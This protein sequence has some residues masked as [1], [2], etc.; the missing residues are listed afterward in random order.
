MQTRN[1]GPK[2]PNYFLGLPPYAERMAAYLSGDRAV[3]VSAAFAEAVSVAGKKA[4]DISVLTRDEQVVLRS[5]DFRWESGPDGVLLWTHSAA[6]KI[7][8]QST[9]DFAW[10]LDQS[11]KVW[12]EQTGTS[13]SED[14]NSTEPP[15]WLLEWASQWKNWCHRFAS[16]HY[17]RALRQ[18]QS[19]G[20]RRPVAAGV[21]ATALLVRCLKVLLLEYLP[22][23]KITQRQATPKN[24][25]TKHLSSPEKWPTPTDLLDVRNHG[26]NAREYRDEF[27][28]RCCKPSE[29]QH[30]SRGREPVVINDT[31]TTLSRLVQDFLDFVATK[32]NASLGGSDGLRFQNPF[33]PRSRSGRLLVPANDNQTQGFTP[34][35][36]GFWRETKYVAPPAR[37]ADKSCSWISRDYPH[38]AAWEP[39]AREFIGRSKRS[40][41]TK[42]AA[43]SVFVDRY[44]NTAGERG[45]PGE[46]LGIGVASR[47]VAD[48]FSADALLVRYNRDKVPNT[49]D[50]LSENPDK[51]YLR[52]I[53]DEFIEDILSFHC[54]VQ[55]ENGVVRLAEYGNPFLGSDLTDFRGSTPISTVRAAMPYR[56]IRRMR[57]ILVPGAHFCDWAWAQQAQQSV[58]GN[59]AD[60][61]E[62]DETIIDREDPDC[63]WRQRTTGK[64]KDNSERTFYEMWSPV[65]WVVLLTKLNTALRTLQVRV[66][67][68]GESD[69]WRFDLG[70]W[71]RLTYPEMGSAGS[72]APSSSEIPIGPWVRNEL[73]QRNPELHSAVVP[74]DALRKRG[75]RRDPQDWSNGALRRVFTNTDEGPGHFDTVLYVNTNKSADTNK[76]G[77]AKGFEIPLPLLACPLPPGREYWIRQGEHGQAASLAFTSRLHKEAWLD[78]LGENT[79]WWLAKLRNWQERYNPVKRRMGWDQLSG[80]G[81]MPEKSDE[82][83]QMY[84]PACFLFREPAARKGGKH[85]GPEYPIADSVVGSAWWSLNKELQDQLNSARK[86]G[87]AEIK[88]VLNSDGVANRTCV[89][90]LHSIRV[91]LITALIVDGKVPVEIVQKMVGH[92]RLVMTIYYTVVSPRRMQQEI[93]AGF[94]RAKEEEIESE[95]LFL[96]NASMEELRS[97]AA[98]NDEAS[99]FAALGISKKPALRSVV[100]WARVLGGICPVGAATHDTEGGLAA[101]CFNGGPMISGAHGAKYEP[102]EGGPGTCVN[103]RFLT[104]LPA[105]LGELQAVY[106][107]AGYRKHEI[108]QR[109]LAQEQK[110]R[111][112]KDAWD[113]GEAQGLSKLELIALERAVDAA[114]D[115]RESILADF[116]VEIVTAANAERLISRLLVIMNGRAPDESTE[117]LV[118]NGGVVEAKLIMSQTNSE[119]LHAARISLHS[120]LHPELNPSGAILRASQIMARKLYTEGADPFVLLALPEQER[121]RAMNAA[122]RDLANRFGADNF[123]AGL[124]M[125]VRL[126]ES[127]DSI[128][129]ALGIE[130][131]SLN[132][133]ILGF[134]STGRNRATIPTDGVLSFP[135]LEGNIGEDR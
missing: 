131:K 21:G 134:S 99:A 130:R 96:Q 89:F 88:L 33:L 62:V 31:G 109:A 82:Q 27:W 126:I 77:A 87:E 110:V 51:T 16:I 97:K 125:A 45:A 111:D 119:M 84:R 64:A 42:I 83:Y 120:E 44:L 50:R 24:D 133:W 73:A 122:I 23:S 72:A 95:R 103:C 85:L 124:G 81:L 91:S 61:F 5:L 1:A 6:T 15:P 86:D 70:A 63:V 28:L 117:A 93:S 54:S 108:H 80:T 74:Q 43:L 128:A 36:R 41:S 34:E 116:A 2:R 19:N 49:L 67:D 14:A 123:D 38:L 11:R 101:G 40:V 107:T 47:P 75:G 29:R 65:R 69:T 68:S 106:E 127:P 113:R 25:D 9:P 8:S 105:H 135:A 37:D 79:H 102:V 4:F 104:T 66:L 48:E 35:S 118:L 94:R 71:S 59:S 132:E 115:I 121:Q 112:A 39:Y 58:R 26:L 53:R 56:W 60:W 100:M 32:L 57:R 52:I 7:D 76:E 129:D 22:V 12:H 30:T 18:S 90:D 46:C 3:V 114:E 78:E 55:D 17:D 20:G 92:S 13:A 98:F 10:L